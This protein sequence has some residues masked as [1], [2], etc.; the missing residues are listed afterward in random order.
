LGFF[1]PTGHD[2][3]KSMKKPGTGVRYP[4]GEKLREIRERKGITMKDLALQAGIS[5]SMISQIER[6]KVSPSLDT[7]F[8]LIDI[9]GVDMEYLFMNFKQ[10]K[11]AYVVHPEDRQ[12]QIKSGVRYE[13]LT[14]IMTHEGKKDL[15]AFLVKMP[16]GAEKGDVDYGH[17]GEELGFI[18][19]G[20]GRLIYGK[21][22]YE[23]KKSDC[24][25]FASDIPHKLI[26]TGSEELIAFWVAT[27]PRK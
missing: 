6:N 1:N 16:I 26:N 19:Q 7:L 17:P 12:V 5:E 11:E 21:R 25:T 15:E 8:G 20:E 13:E 18:F 23:L 4:F 2:K 10:D 3:L 27:P 24:I 14:S 9:L 22:E